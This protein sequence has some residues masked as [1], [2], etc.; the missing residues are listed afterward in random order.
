MEFFAVNPAA[1]RERTDCA[2]V[3][4]YEKAELSAAAAD[5]DKQ[6]G[7]R[8]ASATRNGDF[9][10]KP[11][12]TLL[13]NDLKGTRAARILLV[14]LGSKAKFGRKQ[15]RK[16]LGSAVA[17]V[18]RTGARDAVSYLTQERIADSDPYYSAR[19]AAEIVRQA[20]YSIPDLKSSKKPPP[21]ALKRFGIA[22]TDRAARNAAQRGLEH[23]DA[24]SHGAALAKDLGNL[25]ANICTP[26]YLA[27]AARKLGRDHRSVAVR[28]LNESDMKRLHMGS[29]M[30]VA[31]GSDEP[32]KL[33]VLEYR[34]GERGAP[35]VALVGKGVTFDT[36]GISIKPA[37]AMDE[38]KFDM[39]GAASVLGA[40]RALAELGLPINVV[41]VVPATEN[42]PNGHA[43]KPGDVVTSMSGLTIEVL[44]TDAEGRLILCDAITYARRYKPEVLIDIATLTGACV[45]AL[46]SQYS[47]LFSNDD[48]LG[49]TLAAAGQR[50]DDRVWALPMGEEY[51]DQ[52][53]SNFAD[54]ANIG[55]REAGAIT[56][57]CFLGKFT[58]GL[59]W[60]HLDIAG[61]AWLGGA[62]KG[63]TGRPVPLLV[64]FLL[65]R[66][67]ALP[68]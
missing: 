47:G 35:P 1:A 36:G 34:G 54:V 64:E 68:Q 58:E 27:N 66:A 13:L 28:I 19:A 48:K 50:S 14:G 45:M 22:V 10:G 26:T 6:S 29:F 61:T 33:I 40:F 37:A 21:A 11:G 17:A 46:G 59:G 31:A 55:G 56:A 42:M 16:A 67:R 63:S 60:A 51:A 25:P 9:R 5:L 20:L 30:S 65:E 7:G 23:G 32:A 53:K 38:M 8:I 52:L 44:N 49:A 41:G 24:I 4:V 18:I 43:T 2:I 12:E 39:C 3:G 57:A 15:Y 62:Q